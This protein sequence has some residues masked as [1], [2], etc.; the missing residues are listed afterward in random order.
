MWQPKRSGDKRISACESAEELRELQVELIDRFGLLPEPARNLLRIAGIKQRAAA[1]GI[2]KI[3]VADGGGYLAFGQESAIDALAL[4]QLVQGDS[5]T[6][7]LQGS[8]RLRFG[9]DLADLD[10][11]FTFIEKLLENLAA[12]P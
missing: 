7:R 8:H 9:T 11:R 2:D 5:R 6:F 12:K 10:E 3:D 4:V 1:L